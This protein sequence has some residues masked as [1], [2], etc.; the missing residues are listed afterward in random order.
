MTNINLPTPIVSIEWLVTHLNHPN[1]VILDATKTKVGQKE[2][3]KAAKTKRIPRSRN[4]DLQNTFKDQEATL[5]NTMPS[6]K[7]FE[8]EIRKIGINNESV[9]VVYD[10]HGVY[11][12]PRAWW[13]FKT[14]GHEN[15]AVL[16]GGF[17]AWKE[18]NLPIAIQ[19]KYDGE[20]GNFKINYQPNLIK[21]A[22]EV[23]ATLDKNDVAILD[24]RSDGRFHGTAPEPRAHLKGGHIPGSQ[25][26]P[27]SK[28]IKDGKLMSP[29]ELK[30]IYDAFHL[31]N[32]EVI[33]TCGSGMTACVIA[34]GAEVA[35]YQSKAIF[36]GSWT[37]WGDGDYPVE[38]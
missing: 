13:I 18:A 12:S 17:P 26:L 21:S 4:F 32:K 20:A 30:E 22:A 3:S 33:F 15:V 19:A 35:G 23:L 6:P 24:A 14:M 37:E 38:K 34:L 7:Y 16:N 10:H 29:T 5:P 27:S 2:L 28:I 8:E 25:N 1:L 36:D 9:I 31:E 11:S